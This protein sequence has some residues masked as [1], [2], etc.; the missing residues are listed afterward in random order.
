MADQ[1]PE[2]ASGDPRLDAILARLKTKVAEN[3]VQRAAEA[4]IEPLRA[5]Q[6]TPRGV[7][8][9]DGIGRECSGAAR[10]SVRDAAR[11]DLPGGDRADRGASGA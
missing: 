2:N 9:S 5:R 7:G 10:G 11:S 8:G 6:A 3:E 1:T 4:E